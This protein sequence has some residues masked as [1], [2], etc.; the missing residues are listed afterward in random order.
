LIEADKKFQA[1][2]LVECQLY[3]SSVDIGVGSHTLLAAPP[4]SCVVSR[5]LQSLKFSLY[6]IPKLA[7]GV[8]AQQAKVTVNQAFHSGQM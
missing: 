8:F 1:S 4:L 5:V 2:P 7:N 6:R 3:H